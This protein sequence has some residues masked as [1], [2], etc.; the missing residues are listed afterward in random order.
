MSLPPPAS[1]VRRPWSDLPD[2]T[3]AAIERYLGAPVTS[4]ETQPGGFSPAVAARITA[5]NGRRAF[6]KA[7]EGASNPDAPEMYRREA[8]IAA[9]LPT[10]V[11]TPRLLRSFDDGET[12]WV[13]LI[14]E[15]IDGWNPETPWRRQDLLRVLEMLKTL[16]HEPA[17]SGMEL[18]S[19]AAHLDGFGGWRTLAANPPAG[20][21]GWSARNLDRLAALEADV[22][23]AA[24]GDRL[25]HFDVRADNILL[26]G[27][28]AYLVDWPHA[29]I[30]DPA[31]DLAGFAPSVA[32]QGG[33]DPEEL[34]R[35]SAVTADP[36]A[37][38]VIVAAVAGYFTQRAL[39]PSPPGLPTLR[40]FQEA[41]GVVAR[42]WLAQRTGWA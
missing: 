30:G 37:V 10:W 25:L 13:V 32:M 14:F 16:W 18:Q 11:P 4:A 7:V 9:A 21:D 1:G 35:L 8:R 39:L 17:P 20:L 28:R 34:L 15:E 31:A 29:S 27:E 3:V 40:A 2:S 26:T 33:P 23:R 42:R 36:D 5:A 41:Q 6:V 22:L 38:T 24:G 12:G 19:A